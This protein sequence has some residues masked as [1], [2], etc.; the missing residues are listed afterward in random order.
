M[1]SLTGLASDVDHAG[2]PSPASADAAVANARECG[3]RGGA[4]SSQPEDAC[5]NKVVM[6]T[7]PVAV[8]LLAG[9]LGTARRAATSEGRIGWNNSMTMSRSYLGATM[10]RVTLT[11]VA[12]QAQWSIDRVPCS[13]GSE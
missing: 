9:S 1:F 6:A 2:C 5:P 11:R 4:A 13:P 3:T 8:A 10:V 12:K 7:R